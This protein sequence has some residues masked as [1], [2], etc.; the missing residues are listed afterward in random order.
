MLYTLIHFVCSIVCVV[1]CLFL[2]L[3]PIFLYILGCGGNGCFVDNTALFFVL[4]FIC[5]VY[6]L[7][8]AKTIAMV[9][10][11]SF[12]GLLIQLFALPLGEGEG[13]RLMSESGSEEMMLYGS[14]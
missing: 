8:F 11:S 10:Y 9:L 6:N 2:W 12:A 1:L 5:V 3:L 13:E 14:F 7:C 4:L